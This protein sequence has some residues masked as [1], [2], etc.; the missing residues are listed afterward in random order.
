MSLPI[1]TLT[2]GISTSSTLCGKRN[3]RKF[4]F[5]GKAGTRDFKERQRVKPH[6]LIPIAKRGVRDTGY[7]KDGLW[8]DVPEMIPELVVPDLKGFELQPYVSYRSTVEK[9]PKF[10]AELL[11]DL[12]Y[13]E[14]IK[15]DFQAGKLDENGQPLEPSIEESLTPEEAL[16]QSQKTG[17]DLFTHEAPPSFGWPIKNENE[18]EK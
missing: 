7:E 5:Y 4:L 9:Q 16:A 12:I 2:R 18:Q 8:I 1:L 6:P 17:S 11:F 15:Q 3:I 14:K 10:T 13:A